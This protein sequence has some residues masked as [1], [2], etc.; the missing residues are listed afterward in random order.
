MF[1]YSMPAYYSASNNNDLIER[2]CVYV[3]KCSV[4]YTTCNE[5]TSLGTAGLTTC[6][7]FGSIHA[8]WSGFTDNFPE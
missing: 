8:Y 1:V 4:I 7:F 3:C 2:E 6:Q 5:I